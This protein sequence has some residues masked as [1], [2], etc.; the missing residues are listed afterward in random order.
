MSHAYSSAQLLRRKFA[1]ALTVSTSGKM[2]QA[3][4][5][6]LCGAMLQ[7]NSVR[8][9]KIWQR[10]FQLL[11]PSAPHLTVWIFFLGSYD[12]KYVCRR[13]LCACINKWKFKEITSFPEINEVIYTE[14]HVNAICKNININK[15]IQKRSSNLINSTFRAFFFSS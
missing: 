8:H 12:L 3:R 14:R 7:N 6:F 4:K 1:S 9:N 10:E 15:L 2:L 13:T 11:N 5:D